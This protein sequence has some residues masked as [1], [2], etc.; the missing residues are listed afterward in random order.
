MTTNSPPSP[1]QQA[2]GRRLA[3]ALARGST[4]HPPA[5]DGAAPDAQAPLRSPW[6]VAR[7][8]TGVPSAAMQALA[9]EQARDPAGRAQAASLM[10]RCLRHYREQIRP[11]DEDD[12][13]GV[14]LACF[15]AACVQAQD[16]RAVTP[17]RWRAVHDWVQAWAGDGDG[18]S[19]SGAAWDT[20]PPA[21]QADFFERMACMAVAIGEWTVVASRQGE[22]AMRSAQMLAASS[23]RAQLGLE[24]SA[25]SATLR[26]GGARAAAGAAGDPSWGDAELPKAPTTPGAGERL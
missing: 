19:G 11:D 16:G 18:D 21:Q 2:V 17:E 22:S 8:G 13:A 15:L 6:R 9:R 20:T 5:H 3:H 4:V 25:L 12:D 1:W 14:A 10:A 26:A 23:L 24:L 7:R